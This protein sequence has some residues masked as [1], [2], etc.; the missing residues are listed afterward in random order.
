MNNDNSGQII[1]GVNTT[2]NNTDVNNNSSVASINQEVPVSI[3][4]SEN[5][6]SNDGIISV[7]ANQVIPSVMDNNVTTA[8]NQADISNSTG[9]DPLGF[10]IP[11][12]SGND[13]NGSDNVANNID[14]SVSLVNTNEDVESNNVLQSIEILNPDDTQNNNDKNNEIINSDNVTST[15]TYLGHIFLF[16]IPVIGFIMLIIKAFDKKNKNISNWAKAML[17]YMVISFVAGIIIFIL[18]FAVAGIS[19]SQL[20]NNNTYYSGDSYSNNGYINE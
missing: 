2:G 12:I 9:N 5:N 10:D 20:I 13:V 7:N 17:L 16:S 4:V 6:A 15:G 14:N 1:F 3:P 18:L 11:S 8:N 19:I